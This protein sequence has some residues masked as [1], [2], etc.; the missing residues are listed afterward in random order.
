ME[1]EEVVIQG[2]VARSELRNECCVRP[3]ELLQAIVGVG[4]LVDVVQSFP[5]SFFWRWSCLLPL[6]D[7]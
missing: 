5:G 6:S 1:A 3:V 7:G 2:A 4:G